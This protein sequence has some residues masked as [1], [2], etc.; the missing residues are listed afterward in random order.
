MAL[1][2]LVE[3]VESAGVPGERY[4]REA[5]L[6]HAQLE[7]SHTLLTRSEYRR[8]L[9]AALTTS[10]NPALG[11][12]MGEHVGT[13]TLG[14]LGYLIE[15][16]GSL[17]DALQTAAR[18]TRIMTQGPCVEVDEEGDV[19]TI[20]CPLIS[21][22]MAEV[23]L[24]AEF[25]TTWLL[26]LL[27]QFVGDDAQPRA[28]YF[29]YAAPAHRSEYTRIFG[30]R[31][32]FSHSFTGLSFDA[33]WLDRAQPH[34]SPELRRLLQAQA[35][36]ALAKVDRDA[37]LVERVRRWLSAQPLQTRPTMDEVARDLGMSA[38][39]LRRHLS[40]EQVPYDELV[41]DARA[42]RAKDL[43]ADPRC[44]VQEAGYALGYETPGAFSRAFKRWTGT[45]PTAYRAPRQS[46]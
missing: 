7:D 5:G 10:E 19:V 43:L 27:R 33:S 35:D 34:R 45:A 4:L 42:A 16:S 22:G 37:P 21:D 26:R 32:V 17:R 9:R 6:T 39:S 2:V 29:P 36:Q 13:A 38:R 24:T 14:V 23:P 40:G 28:A 25:V 20:R 31:E 15:Q 18:Y 3:A 46:T 41:E 8:A 44:S 11:L 30:G 12:H 1:R